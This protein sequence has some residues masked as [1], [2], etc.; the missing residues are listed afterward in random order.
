MRRTIARSQPEEDN[1]AKVERG[2][3]KEK[4]SRALS[5]KKGEGGETSA[6]VEPAERGRAPQIGVEAEK[7]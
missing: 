6:I 7:P 3:I 1:G 2:V 4:G 5:H